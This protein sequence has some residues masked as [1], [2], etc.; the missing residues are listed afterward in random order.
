MAKTEYTVHF[1]DGDS[2]RGSMNTT[3]EVVR[4]VFS[5]GNFENIGLGPEDNIR[6]VMS[7]EI[8]IYEN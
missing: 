4:K 5:V 8:H 6:Q 3:P 1:D 7:V 2:I